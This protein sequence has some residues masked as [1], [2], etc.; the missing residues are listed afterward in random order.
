[1][2]GPASY[3]NEQLRDLH[4]RLNIDQAAFDEMTALLEETLEDF[5]FAREDVDQIVGAV[6]SRRVHIVSDRS[7]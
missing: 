4:A 7:S 3:S 1:M 5:E 2:G 6:K